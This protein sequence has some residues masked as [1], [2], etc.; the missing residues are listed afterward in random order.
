MNQD[1]KTGQLVEL[2][3][4]HRDALEI[5]LADF[6]ADPSELHGYFCPRQAPIEEAVS[7][8]ELWSCGKALEQG[9]VPCSTWFWEEDGALQGVIN[10]RHEL[11]DQL[12]EHGGHLGY[13]VAPAHRRKG[14]A[15]RMLAAALER[16]ASLGIERALLTCHAHNE[17]SWRTIE[18][19]GGVLEREAWSDASS[20]VQRWYWIDLTG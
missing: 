8:L 5:F 15:K 14:V 7:S 10:L 9:W 11:T 2:Q 1:L 3:L 17:G 20:G 12:R 18:R 16:T 4:R 13:C 19:N 6:D